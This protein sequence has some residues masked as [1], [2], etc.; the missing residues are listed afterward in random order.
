MSPS[1]SA[2]APFQDLVDESLDEATFLWHRWEGELTSATRSL[3]EVWSWTEDRLHGAL[4]GVR[5]AGT[6]LVDVAAGGLQSGEGDRVAV[7]AGLLASTAEPAA[8]DLLGEMMNIA[9]A[10]KLRSIVRGLELLGSNQG[11]RAAA[12]VLA[13]RGPAGAGA[14]CRLKAFRRVAPGDELVSAFKSNIPEIQAAA[15]RAAIHVPALHAEE[16]ITAALGMGD[17]GVRYAAAEC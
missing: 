4:D 3:D 6:R 12:S 17:P 15:V 8:I 11:L 7:C 16:F 2:A 14:L 1:H 9:D 5:V 10:E 13:E